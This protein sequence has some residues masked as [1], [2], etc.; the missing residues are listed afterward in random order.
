VPKEQQVLELPGSKAFVY[1][2]MD[3]VFEPFH[4]N[5]RPVKAGEEAGRIHCLWDPMRPPETLT[6]NADGILY[7]CRQPGRVQPGNCCVVVA[8][9]YEGAIR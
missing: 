4:V 2:T 1:A 8:A 7:G 5:G 3:G 9:P 6:Y